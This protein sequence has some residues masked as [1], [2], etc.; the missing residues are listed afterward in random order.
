[1][2]DCA[3]RVGTG[4]CCSLLDDRPSGAVRRYCLA[5]DAS[6]YTLTLKDHLGKAKDVLAGRKMFEWLL[7]L[8]RNGVFIY[9]SSASPLAR[10]LLDKMAL[11]D[12]S[13]N[14]YFKSWI[15]LYIQR[16]NKTINVKPKKQS[17][18]AY[19]LSRKSL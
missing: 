6:V 9:L 19:I 16:L 18:I 4:C 17:C 15:I 13:E 2:D 5:G 10:V 14:R 3:D 7:F 12:P 8:Y 1:M 11:K